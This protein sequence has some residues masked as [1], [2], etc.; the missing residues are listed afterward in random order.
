[1]MEMGT[2]LPEKRAKYNSKRRQ[3]DLDFVYTNWNLPKEMTDATIH[4]SEVPTKVAKKYKRAIDIHWQ[5]WCLKN[6]DYCNKHYDGTQS[7][8][9]GKVVLQHNTSTLA[10]MRTVLPK[11]QSKT[12]IDIPKDFRKFSTDLMGKNISGSKA[13]AA[14]YQYWNHQRLATYYNGGKDWGHDDELCLRH[15]NEALSLLPRLQRNE[16]PHYEELLARAFRA[17]AK[18]NMKDY[19]AALLEYRVVFASIRLLD[20]AGRINMSDPKNSLMNMVNIWPHTMIRMTIKL[21][22][23]N[24]VQRPYFTKDEYLDLMKELAYGIYSPSSQKCLHCGKTENLSLC[25][26]CKRAWFCDKTCAAKS[27]KAGHKGSCGP[28]KYSGDISGGE[29]ETL[30]PYAMPAPYLSRV[31]DE[32]EDKEDEGDIHYTSGSMGVAIINAGDRNFIAL[33]RDASSGEA[34]DALTNEAFE[35]MAGRTLPVLSM[36][37]GTIHFHSHPDDPHLRFRT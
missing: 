26:G 8:E 33:C 30:V 21:K 7:K 9:R 24:G 5:D 12:I 20:D 16:I 2:W 37:G 23:Q 27:W 22:I 18:L 19:E 36:H 10:H 3:K 34:F 32:L 25:S 17:L 6:V 28:K 15:A 1:M 14:V 4:I 29:K 31:L 35:L 13:S 11:Y